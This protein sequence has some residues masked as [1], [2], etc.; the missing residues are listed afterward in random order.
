MNRSC[1][2]VLLLV[3]LLLTP[4]R[5]PMALGDDP[6]FSGP[7]V[8]ESITPF[9]MK[10]AFADQTVD[11]VAE[12]DGK[13]ILLVF[14]HQLTR[15]SIATV[16]A[17]SK[18]AELRKGDLQSAIVF[19]DDDMTALEGRLKRAR[20]ALPKYPLVG[21]SV[22]GAE[23]PGA[24]GL[25]RNA[26]LTILVAKENKVSAN[27][28]LKDASV[29]V[30]V[31][32]IVGAACELIGGDAPQLSQLLP[33]AAMRR[34]GGGGAEQLPDLLRGVIRKTATPEQVDAAA[35]KVEAYVSQNRAA[36]KRLGEILDRIVGADKLDQYGSDHARE[37][38]KRWHRKYGGGEKK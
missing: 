34:G 4:I 37:Y 11:P 14:V 24:Y 6:F 7:Q 17:V 16:R 30:D 25:N 21:M 20:H 15:P 19:L 2:Q 31:P 18:F 3:A 26:T 33:R 9:K 22:D 23:G 35:K 10:V 8:G 29:A 36:A 12:A 28:A 13:P 5:A 1:F 27:F 38:L 32:K